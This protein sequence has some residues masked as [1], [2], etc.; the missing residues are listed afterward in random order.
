MQRRNVLLPEPEL[1]RMAMTSWSCAVTETPFNTST[2]PKLLWIF[3]TTRAVAGGNGSGICH[4][5]RQPWQNYLNEQACLRGSTPEFHA[6]LMP[7]VPHMDT[8]SR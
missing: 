7:W 1:P 4:P 3:S 8:A 5:W 2:D 6:I